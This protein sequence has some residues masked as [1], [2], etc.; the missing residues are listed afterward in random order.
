MDD[1]GG[2]ESRGPNEEQPQ[3]PTTVVKKPIGTGSGGCG[4]VEISGPDG[5]RFECRGSCGVWNRFLGRS[6]NKVVQNAEGGVQVF[7]HCSGG[8]WDRLRGE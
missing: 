2:T 3:A 8:W 7:C 6:C 4:L 1:E 5:V